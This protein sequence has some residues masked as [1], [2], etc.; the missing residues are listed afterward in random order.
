MLDLSELAMKVRLDMIDSAE[1][2]RIAEDLALEGHEGAAI[3]ILA[4][5]NPRRDELL[6]LAEKLCE[7]LG[8][9]LPTYEEAINALLRQHALR[10]LHSPTPEVALSRMVEIV[11]DR[12]L[13]EET[14]TAY[15]GD[16][17]G[18]EHL[19]GLHW[20]FDDWKEHYGSQF[21]IP[22]KKLSEARMAIREAAEDWLKSH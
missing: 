9:T 19:I 4:S 6:A 3:E 12:F 16:S 17:R 20:G 10:I 11:Y 13:T 14:D 1:L 22:K 2:S 8:S 21:K 5:S 18:L 7:E 15:V